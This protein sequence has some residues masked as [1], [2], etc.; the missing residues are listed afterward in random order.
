MRNSLL[1][2]IIVI[3]FLN[4]LKYCKNMLTF[5]VNYIILY[6]K[7]H[8]ITGFGLNKLNLPFLTYRKVVRGL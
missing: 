5:S 1:F 4:V 7:E 3:S 8:T 6:M 2:F